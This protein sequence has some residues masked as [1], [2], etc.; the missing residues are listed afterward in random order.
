MTRRDILRAYLAGE[1]SASEAL[2]NIRDVSPRPLTR[3]LT[4]GQKGL[5]ALQR[6]SPGMAAYNVPLC[7][8]VRRLDRDAFKEAVRV[9]AERNP[10][11]TDA[12]VEEG[13]VPYR[14]ARSLGAECIYHEDISRLGADEIL[15]YLER[16]VKEPFS[17]RDGLLRV[18]ILDRS[19][20]ETLILIVVHHIAFDGGS[21]L[22]LL[23]QL[24]EAY[25][26]AVEGREQTRRAWSAGYDDFAEWEGRLLA[27]PEAADHLAY[28]K[29]H[30][31]GAAAVLDLPTD[32]PRGRTLSFAGA[33][34]KTHVSGELTER[35]SLFCFTHGVTPA[36]L[37]LGA[38]KIL[39]SRY[40]GEEDV[41][42]GLSVAVR[43]RA[44]F[45]QLVG[46][47]INMMPVRTRVD[48]SR[49]LLEFI[50]ELQVC[51]A[52]NLDHSAYPFSALVRNLN[53]P[54]LADRSPVF[55]VAYTYQNY[56]NADALGDLVTSYQDLLP[57]EFV[58]GLHQQGEY[59]L[60][61]EVYQSKG[62]SQINL[63]YNPDL[64]HQATIARMGGH[65]SK[66]LAEI[67]ENP[68]M[69]LGEYSLLTS[70]ELSAFREWNATGAD[71][72]KDCPVHELFER[73][74]K[75]TPDAIAIA[76]EEETLTYSE[77]DRRSSLLAGY[78]RNRGV[79]PDCVVGVYIDRS[80][81]MVVCLLSILKAGGAY[82]PIDPEYPAER[83]GYLVED[84]YVGFVLT[85]ARLAERLQWLVEHDVACIVLDRD[86][87][88]IE[89]SGL[90]R[91]GQR[92]EVPTECLA[93]VIYT[94]GS[95]GKPKG[96]MIP[97]RALTNVLVFM[98]RRLGLQAKDRLL[99]LTTYCFDIAGFELFGPLIV[100]GCCVVCPAG[101]VRDAKRLQKEIRR[102]KPS[103]MQATPSTWTMLFRSGWTNE[104]RARIVCGG[105]ALTEALRAKFIKC[106]CEAWNFYGPTETTIWSTA[107]QLSENEALSIGQPI[108][109]TR[110]YIVDRQLRLVPIGL[111]GELCISGAGL[112]RGYHNRPEL[113]AERFVDNPFEPGQRL[114]RT[115]DAARWRPDGTI[116]YL[117]RKDGQ[118]K[119]KGHR[120]ELG[121]IECEL[122]G[123]A[124]I[125]SCV[126]V[127][128]ARDDSEQLVAYYVRN[129]HGERGVD[130]RELRAYL[131]AR[132]PGYMIPA[133][134]IEVRDIPLTPNGKIDRKTLTLTE[135][136]RPDRA[137]NGAP[138]LEIEKQIA[139]IWKSVLGQVAIDVNDVFFEVGGDSILAVALAEKI[140]ERLNCDFDVTALFRYPSIRAIGAHIGRM[141]GN[142]EDRRSSSVTTELSSAAD[143]AAVAHDRWKQDAGN[144][145]YPGY[146]E[147]SV[148]I[149]GMSCHFPGAKNSREFWANLVQ[150]RESIERLSVAELRKLG[151]PE[152]FLE[153][154]RYVAARSTIEGKELFDAGFFKIS[155]KDAELMDPQLR[156]LL[157]HAWKAVEDAGYVSRQMSDTGVFMSAS[158]NFY[159]APVSIDVEGEPSALSNYAGYQRW[160]LSQAG[161][162]PTII[163]YKLGL[164]GPSYQVH[165]NCSSSLVSL[166]VACQSIM[167]GEVHQAL[168]GAATLLPYEARGY[169]HQKGLNFS[170]D[171]RIRA[172]DASADGMIGGE[173]VA[174]VLLKRAAEAVRAGDRIYALIRGVGVN[175]DG[176]EKAGFYAPSVQGQAEAICKALEA[177]GVDPETISYVEAHGTGT[178]LG[179]PIEFAALT[180][181]FRRHTDKIQFCG[182]GSVKS[183]I[184]HLD[185]VAGLA[186][187][188]KVALGLQRQEIP[189]TINFGEI[190]PKI[191]LDSSPFYILEKNK[192]FERDD[193]PLRAAVSSFGIGGTNAHAILEQAPARDTT[194]KQV[195]SDAG[196]ETRYVVPLSARTAEQL[197]EY[198][199]DLLRFISEHSDASS[200]LDDEPNI[201]DLSYTLQVGREAMEVRFGAVV[202]SLSELEEKLRDYLAGKEGIA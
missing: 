37:F 162:I 81:E 102:V 192:R 180:D 92:I 155:P 53:V 126:V 13:G 139:D 147:D 172:F 82:L 8:R 111:A 146:Y 151:V 2:R 56:W 32:R 5:W 140:K 197:K 58:D 96:V 17:L 202:S 18:G 106:G 33:T 65:I 143:L 198:A 129:G 122:A 125:D 38:F 152:Q 144:V 170:S 46:Y 67:I 70:P 166:H 35:I 68:E 66:L 29:E 153:D 54:R 138:E 7:F 112:A 19:Q 181:A 191:Q 182:L 109:N 25:R 186:G 136:V 113:T 141:R 15:P 44:E 118:V 94:S 87:A 40:C 69:A 28:W 176:A 161:T 117:G 119:V 187:V 160:L 61:M 43:P 23:T 34:W 84:S 12:I 100:G 91:L 190:N 51:V 39:L 49:T 97:H 22:P 27:G 178:E 145:E 150:G 120:V 196:A 60:E 79:G 3:G 159:G 71:Y 21:V 173:G 133:D 6:M 148:A 1:I 101:A 157:L 185:T 195:I 200:E 134:F 174:V 123:H 103:I 130:S 47:F 194:N 105:E 89:R 9:L 184:G 59:E 171:G 93:Y 135:V 42:V 78:L 72:A 50:R 14:M 199:G 121:E 20:D 168:V 86:W 175:N 26:G 55:Q 75:L 64:F 45:E 167:R 88:E 163:S 73:Q 189:R 30:L 90:E 177:A 188:I 77:L 164:R 48:G 95:T 108:A 128:R 41:V 115:G 74:V 63:K 62:G 83:V 165:S 158:N 137:E 31:S 114:Y 24:L 80:I 4:E 156:L 52:D 193:H 127:T 131:A 99:A 11:L 149:I 183:N 110:I 36:M 124:G 104:E 16:K 132:L 142:A 76:Y 85:Q 201:A 169:L 116:E 179:D 98:S 10:V 57:I 107:H 154:P